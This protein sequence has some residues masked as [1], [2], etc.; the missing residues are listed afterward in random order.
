MALGPCT[1][2]PF[3]LS[4]LL[5]PVPF[6]PH[7]AWDELVI[8]CF[9]DLGYKPVT[10]PFTVPFPRSAFKCKDLLKGSESP[11]PGRGLGARGVDTTMFSQCYL[12]KYGEWTVLKSQ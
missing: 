7:E 9:L 2:Q 3:V 1:L 12:G 6:F 10:V 8:M 4:P 5:C 11:S